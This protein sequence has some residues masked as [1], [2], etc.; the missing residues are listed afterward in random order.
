MVS[1]I[2]ALSPFTEHAHPRGDQGERL[3]QQSHFLTHPPQAPV[4]S[5]ETPCC[6]FFNL[7]NGLG[8]LGLCSALCSDKARGQRGLWQRVT[9]PSFSH[10]SRAHPE[11]CQLPQELRGENSQGHRRATCPL[12]HRP[13]WERPR[14]L[15]WI[16]R[17]CS[18]IPQGLDVGTQHT[19]CICGSETWKC[20]APTTAPQSP[21]PAREATRSIFRHKTWMWLLSGIFCAV[22]L[23]PKS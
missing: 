2:A 14:A 23:A 1:E 20:C 12:C 8:S 21:S 16:F 5:L 13:G 3:V 7:R 17:D 19:G 18:D 10:A 22:P 15:G 6:L 4:Q 11:L 9:A